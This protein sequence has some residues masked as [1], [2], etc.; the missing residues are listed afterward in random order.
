MK[1]LSLLHTSFVKAWT[2]ILR[3]FKSCQRRVGDSQCL[4]SLSIVSAENK[5]TICL[6]PVNHTTKTIHI[7]YHYSLST[8]FEIVVLK[9]FA[10]FS[11]KPVLD[12]LFNKVAGLKV[13]NFIKRRLRHRYFPIN[14]AKFLRTS[15]LWNTIVCCFCLFMLAFFFSEKGNILYFNIM[16]SISVFHHYWCFYIYHHYGCYYYYCL[17]VEVQL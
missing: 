7:L 9:T 8:L 6:S 14:I 3:S 13:C 12:S 2:Q 17:I 15:F 1:Q 11:G 5:T 10:I 16:I 4:R